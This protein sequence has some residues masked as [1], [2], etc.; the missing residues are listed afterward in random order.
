MLQTPTLISEMASRMRSNILACAAYAGLVWISALFAVSPLGPSALRLDLGLAF[1]LLYAGGPQI[2]PGLMLGAALAQAAPGPA[3]PAFGPGWALE[4]L[5]ALVTLV[6]LAGLLRLLRRQQRPTLAISVNDALL[7]APGM[8]VLTLACGFAT[9]VWSGDPWTGHFDVLSIQAGAA[10][11]SILASVPLM[12]GL[13]HRPRFWASKNRWLV[14][15]PPLALALISLLLFAQLRETAETERRDELRALARDSAYTLQRDMS[16]YI[17]ALRA[18]EAYFAGS[19]DVT[20]DEFDQFARSLQS[21]LPGLFAVAQNAYVSAGQ[22]AEF[23][24]RMRDSGLADFEIW[25]LDEDGQRRTSPARD[26][27]V[28][29][30]FVRFEG[31]PALKSL[32]FDMASES[33]RRAALES[34]LYRGQPVASGRVRLVTDSDP[35]FDILV[36]MTMRSAGQPVSLIGYAGLAVHGSEL[37]RTASAHLPP[38]VL[39]RLFDRSAPNEQA[40]L[41]GVAEDYP[42][43]TGALRQSHVFGIADRRWE[44]ELIALPEF[45]VQSLPGIAI[46]TLWGGLT[47]AALLAVILLMLARPAPLRIVEQ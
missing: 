36:L 13:A 11:F 20:R 26:Y 34:A 19:A 38:H 16:T 1:L 44:L 6:A 15:A 12:A 47:I 7:V 9:A 2:L 4:L 31:K 40:W 22:R 8:A 3:S 10:G 42:V 32:G 46:A 25:E 18:V 33:T 29:V 17:V 41:H 37:M 14:W 21:P 45:M 35:G 39:P 27:Y 30:T 43:P 28:P 24:K 23:E 5:D